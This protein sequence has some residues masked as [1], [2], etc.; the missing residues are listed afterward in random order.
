MT[1]YAEKYNVLIWWLKYCEWLC[2]LWCDRFCYD[3]Q[4]LN[5]A[6]TQGRH[7]PSTYIIVE[8]LKNSVYVNNHARERFVKFSFKLYPL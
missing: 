8:Y 1:K 3:E 2:H 6:G 7:F 4:A 5:K